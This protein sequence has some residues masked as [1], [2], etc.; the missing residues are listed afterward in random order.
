MAEYLNLTATLH[1]HSSPMLSSA[2]RAR[3]ASKL[4]GV[5][6]PDFALSSDLDADRPSRKA[7]RKASRST[8]DKLRKGARKE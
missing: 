1:A 2:W 4:F 3:S 7:S 5:A 6:P 8:L